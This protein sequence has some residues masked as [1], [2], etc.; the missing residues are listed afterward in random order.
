MQKRLLIQ[1]VMAM[2]LVIAAP[3]ASTANASGPLSAQATVVGDG[4]PD[5]Y[6]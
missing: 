3:I 2:I 5:S 6:R 1:A 4:T